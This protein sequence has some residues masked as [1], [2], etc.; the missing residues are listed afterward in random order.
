[1][2]ANNLIIRQAVHSQEGSAATLYAA[3]RLPLNGLIST[4]LESAQRLVSDLHQANRL[5]DLMCIV[6]SVEFCLQFFNHLNHFGFNAPSLTDGLGF[7]SCLDAY[8]AAPRML[9]S[10]SAFLDR[11]T[12]GSGPLFV[13]PVFTK[14]FTGQVVSVADPGSLQSNNS[15]SL[16]EFQACD[17]DT[18]VWASPVVQFQSEHRFYIREGAILGSARYDLG[19]DENPPELNPEVVTS[20]LGLY[21]SSGLAPAA[22]A[23]DFGLTTDGETRLIELNDAWALGLYA[24]VLTPA[25]YIGFLAARFSQF[26][27][28]QS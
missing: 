28:Q 27:P 1:M 25:D 23:M 6:G 24:K 9:M 3:L 13:K 14:L 10:K 18:L 19:E 8:Y 11:L 7:P 21:E 4:N 2:L 16:L 26:K 22:Y 5:K 17:P 12:D 20:C 15:D